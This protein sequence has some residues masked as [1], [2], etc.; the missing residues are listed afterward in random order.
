MYNSNGV[1]VGPTLERRMKVGLKVLSSGAAANYLAE[2]SVRRAVVFK[3]D[4]ELA[5]Y[6]KISFKTSTKKGKKIVKVVP[7]KLMNWN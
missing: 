4:I 5:P 1:N 7:G 2:L 3:D 6:Q